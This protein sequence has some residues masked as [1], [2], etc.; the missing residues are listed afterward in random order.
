MNWFEILFRLGNLKKYSSSVLYLE[1]SED[2]ASVVLQQFSLSIAAAIAMAW[3][4]FAQLYALFKWQVNPS[5]TMTPSLIL[6]F[7]VI[8]LF[9]YMLKDRI[10]ALTGSWL[11]K[12]AN[13]VLSERS[14]F[15]RRSS[16]LP[17]ICRIQED[18]RFCT[19]KDIQYLRSLVGLRS[20][21]CIDPS[22]WRSSQLQQSHDKYEIGTI[23]VVSQVKDIHRIHL[24]QL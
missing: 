9:S 13:N 3:A 17:P 8:G 18:V 12:K 16:N 10:K 22:G 2:K 19:I 15:F 20:T 7:V 4:L 6:S 11:K 24:E 23:A 21:G 1:Q 14:F 5:D